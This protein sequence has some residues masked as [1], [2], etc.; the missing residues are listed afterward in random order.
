MSL[1]VELLE[2]SFEA[3][4]PQADEFVNSF[5]D[6]LF[7]ANP[8]AKP[9]FA[10]TNMAEQKKKLLDS[11]VLVVEN[12]RMPE[13]LDQALRGLG[14]RH[15]KYGALPEH[16]PLVGIA[17]LTTFE[18]YLGDKWTP[19]VK[20]AWVEAYGA[21]SEIMLD[22]A[23]YSESEIALT[24][25]EPEAEIEEGGLPVELLEKSFEAIKPQ[26]DKF[27]N[28]F[29]DNLF[30]ANPEA[31]P[32]FAG[33][34]MEEQNKRLLNYLVL[35]VVNLRKPEV[36]DQALRGLGAR[37][38]KY[39]A[40]PEHYPLVGNTLLTTFE[41]YLGD[42][43]TPEV[44]QAWVDAY[45]AISEIMLDGADYSESEIAL[46]TPEPE[47]EI[48]EGGLPVEL[49]EKSF[50]AIKPQADEFVNS[51]YDNLFTANP[52]AKPLFAGTNMAE[53]KKKLLNSLVL[54]VENL[55]N[56]EAL[57]SALRGLGARHVKYGALPE[58]YPLVGSALL[59][60]FEQYLKEEWTPEV[61][62]AWVDAYGAISEIMLDGADYSESE[63]ALATPEPEAEIEEGGLPVELLEKSFETIKPQADEFVNSFYD[64]LFTAN[65]EAKPLF[66]GTNMAEQKK[67]LL[68]S[69]VLVVENLRNP[70]ALDSALRG[71]GARHVK[72]GAL[73]EH[74]PLVGSALLTT[75]E[76]YLDDKWTPEV[77]QAWVDAYGAIS[78]IM[79]D[80]ADY[81]QQEIALDSA[82]ATQTLPETAVTPTAESNNKAGLF[83]FVGGGIM[84][85]IAILL[86]VI[87]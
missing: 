40:L 17:L 30:T 54:V 22:G 82:S 51:F 19:E 38:V 23:D 62:Q 47:A 69:L 9:L 12:L 4:K 55:R 39:G 6:N 5:Y 74:Y 11:L 43:W 68:N 21:I 48:E 86:L 81:S 56:P 31:K 33:T 41:Q 46:A 26:A 15:V 10:G 67:K 80:G 44:K 45:G 61:K 79:L 34:N 20:Q 53:Q 70:E 28:S 14:A 25:P 16:Y 1:Q 59:T 57:D 66:A 7:T 76:Q 85:L 60:T 78:E 77:K 65:P 42:K 63:I 32:L 8:D 2:K 18:Q 35:I 27:V 75:F 52:E 24:T 83:T 71:L 49:L 72:Y 73:P 29:Y 36:L 58:H 3:I 37:H 64:N 50:E 84:G 13:I 87:L